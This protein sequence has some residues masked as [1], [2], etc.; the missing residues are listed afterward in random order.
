MKKVF[1]KF[2]SITSVISRKNVKLVLYGLVTIVILG[3]IWRLQQNNIDSFDGK[4]KTYE[5]RI[6]K[7]S[8]FDERLKLEKDILG[9]EKD[10]TTI[11]NGAYT[12]LV[13]ALG[14]LILRG[15]SQL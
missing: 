3:I 5:T 12:T 14:G 7:A 6:I 15:A 4:I 10:K 8:N 9:F 1:S 11:Q 13:Q 2:V